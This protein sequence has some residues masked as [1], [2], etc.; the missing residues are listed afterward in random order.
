MRHEQANSKVS[1]RVSE[2]HR[3]EGREE[4]QADDYAGTA[5][6]DAGRK[7][8]GPWKH[9]KWTEYQTNKLREIAVN[10]IDYNPETGELRWRQAR[11]RSAVG[12]IS[13]TKKS[14]HYLAVHIQ[15]RQY[16]AHRIAWL[17]SY[18]RWPFGDIDHINGVRDD[19]RICNLREV[20]RSENSFNSG[21]KTL[22]TSGFK[23]VHLFK[24]T[25]TYQVQIKVRGKRYNLGYYKTAEEAA[26]V[27]AEAAKKYH[28]EF[29]HKPTIE[30]ILCHQS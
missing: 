20:T 8:Q 15:G 27:Y 3:I 10:L 16:L 11:R 14:N 2:C 23:G 18:G 9:P 29:A 4:V 26:K 24:R 21:K 12:A 7:E 17:I 1:P 28:Q 19:N 25:G 22:N 30:Q 6:K 5:A 13:T